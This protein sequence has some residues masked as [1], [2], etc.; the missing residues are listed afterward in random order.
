M[1]DR[2]RKKDFRNNIKDTRGDAMI[3][4]VCLMFLF[5]AL[6]LAMLLSV[7]AVTGSLKK[8]AALTRCHLAAESFSEMM[9][10][11][12]TDSTKVTEFQTNIRDLLL[13]DADFNFCWH[14]EKEGRVWEF[15]LKSESGMTV[16]ETIRGYDITVTIY[17]G[18]VSN[19]EKEDADRRKVSQTESGKFGDLFLYTVVTCSK[20]N[21]SYHIR[22]KYQMIIIGEPGEEEHKWIFVKA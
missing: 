13:S 8:N 16:G 21:D 10:K 11:D 20:G 15:Q 3:V 18:D 6:S 19:M 22:Q 5:T 4:V 7:S 17:F 14:K 12:L 2:N 9:G 1:S